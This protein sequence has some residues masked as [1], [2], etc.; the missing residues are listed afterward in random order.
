MN[1]M[2]KITTKQDFIEQL[3]KYTT[4]N[5]FSNIFYNFED[6]KIVIEETEQDG[7][8][9]IYLDI[10]SYKN[11][12]IFFIKIIHQPKH[13]IGIKQNHNDGIILKV[14]LANNKINIFLFELKKQLRFNKLKKAAIQLA[15]AY[16]FMKYLMLEE[17][18]NVE[19]YFY[20][21][22]EINNINLDTLDLKLE[23]R[24][25]SELHRT[26]NENKDVIPLQIPFCTY[27]KF[28]F[29]QIKFGDTIS[30]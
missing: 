10:S 30:I 25:E 18:F 29:K 15:S 14:D 8:G 11:E 3:K 23:N 24:F 4:T 20:I 22:Y 13:N 1:L 16:K 17:C 7:Q 19:Y 2:P 26:I 6:N 12:N 27:K 28:N 9:E 5:Q 21:V